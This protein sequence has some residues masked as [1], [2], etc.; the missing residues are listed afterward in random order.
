MRPLG[1]RVLIEPDRPEPVSPGGVFIVRQYEE[2]VV[3][4]T[5]AALGQGR[6]TAKGIPLPREVAV[7]DSVVFAATVGV[8]V[9]IDGKS[10]I[11]LREDDLLGVVPRPPARQAVRETPR[12]RVSRCQKS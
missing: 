1:D 6:F 4:G 9:G 10:F 2:S 12:K 7:G 3:S 5:I 8:E 11:V